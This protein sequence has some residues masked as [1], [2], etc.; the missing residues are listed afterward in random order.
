MAMSA[1]QT[2]N[3]DTPDAQP[4]D[5]ASIAGSYVQVDAY[6]STPRGASKSRWSLSRTCATRWICP[7]PQA[8]KARM[9]IRWAYR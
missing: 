5:L 7:C 8:R 9:S 1:N 6:D 2:L 4:F 3:A